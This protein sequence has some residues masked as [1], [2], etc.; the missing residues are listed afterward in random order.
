MAI[1]DLLKKLVKIGH[2]V[3]EIRMHVDRSTYIL[4]LSGI[5]KK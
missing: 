3:R 5:I 4:I 2:A 1:S